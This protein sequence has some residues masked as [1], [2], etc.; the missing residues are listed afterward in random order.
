MDLNQ[1]RVESDPEIGAPS[2]SMVGSI[3]S[4]E[5]QYEPWRA[6][7]QGAPT[8]MLDW[9]VQ[10]VAR[11]NNP[12]RALKQFQK[13]NPP[14]F[15]GEADPLLAEKWICQIWKILCDGLQ[16]GPEDIFC[17]LH[18]L[19]SR[20]LVGD[21]WRR[22]KNFWRRNHMEIFCCKNLAKSTFKKRREISWHWNFKKW[23]K[24]RWSLLNIMLNLPSYSDMLED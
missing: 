11:R 10:L 23:S 16:R 7:Y 24:I 3:P 15:E 22:C 9:L 21:Y 17:I 13:L 12:N 2:H 1:L 4:P 8:V 5:C 14:A 18:V 6:G 19:R 20:E